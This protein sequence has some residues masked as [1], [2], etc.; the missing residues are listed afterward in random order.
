MR[1]PPDTKATEPQD[2]SSVIAALIHRVVDL[3]ARDHW[4]GPNGE[5]I[6]RSRWDTDAHHIFGETR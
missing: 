5:M 1:T 6:E 4:H 2:I 3:E